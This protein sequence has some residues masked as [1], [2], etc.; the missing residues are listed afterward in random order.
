MAKIKKAVEAIKKYVSGKDDRASEAMRKKL[1]NQEI[2]QAIKKQKQTDKDNLA[3]KKLK[4]QIEH[5]NQVLQK[6]SKK[7]AEQNKKK[8]M[9]AGGIVDRQYLKGR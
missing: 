3:L 8:G 9:K 4:M 5:N 1:N 7:Y 6:N 2:G